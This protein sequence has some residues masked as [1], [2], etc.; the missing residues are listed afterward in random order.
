M[1]EL[2]IRIG[3][4]LNGHRIQRRERE[5]A[6]GSLFLMHHSLPPAFRYRGAERLLAE[7]GRESG[8]ATPGSINVRG[9]VYLNWELSMQSSMA[10]REIGK[11]GA[12]REAG[13]VAV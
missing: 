2:P 1:S 7:K 4:F 3:D 11:Q 6:R 9:A 10:K 8:P 5:R 12:G 13:Q